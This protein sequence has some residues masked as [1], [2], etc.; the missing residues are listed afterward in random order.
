[1]MEARPPGEHTNL[2]RQ[3]SESASVFAAFVTSNMIHQEKKTG[4][5]TTFYIKIAVFKKTCIFLQILV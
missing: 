3:W 4:R 1:M 5:Q 2:V